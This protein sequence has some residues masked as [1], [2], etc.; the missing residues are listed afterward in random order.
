MVQ[1]QAQEAVRQ[2]AIVATGSIVI[3]VALTQAWGWKR[4]GRSSAAWTHSHLVLE[5]AGRETLTSKEAWCAARAV[6]SH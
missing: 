1:V 6:T 4:A 3:S 5:S 2:Y